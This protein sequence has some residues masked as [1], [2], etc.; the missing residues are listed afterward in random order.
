MGKV[1]DMRRLR[2]QQ[3]E[4]AQRAARARA[5]GGAK[6]AAAAAPVA[7]STVAEDL[8]AAVEDALVPRRSSAS[9]AKAAK[10]PMSSTPREPS[11]PPPGRG[12]RGESAD[13]T[14]TCSGCGKQKPM[15]RGVMANHQKGLGKA[16]PG[17]RKPPA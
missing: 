9:A 8:A 14:G 6:T 16:C 1:D 11:V 3:H 2:E 12:K 15:Q 4:E 5:S 13:E 10:V 17:S 7:A